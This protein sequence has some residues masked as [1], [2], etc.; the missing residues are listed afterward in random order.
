[1]LLN[2]ADR[3]RSFKRHDTTKVQGLGSAGQQAS[4][5]VPAVESLF[6]VCGRLSVRT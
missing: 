2:E 1:M 6:L 4:G 5:P 3:P